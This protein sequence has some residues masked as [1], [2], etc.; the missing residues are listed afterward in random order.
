VGL[1]HYVSVANLG[2]Y[3]DK[4]GVRW[5]Y[6][7]RSTNVHNTYLLIHAE[8]GLLGLCGF[9][10]WLLSPILASLAA[11][12]RR[13]M[14]LRE[15]SAACGF[16]IAGT[17]LHSQYEWVTVTATPQYFIAL[18]A[19]VIAAVTSAS[20]RARRTRSAAHATKAGSGTMREPS[21]QPSTKTMGR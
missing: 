3:F 16:A 8:A 2:G 1:N 21:P 14:P 18:M 12:F 6:E 7:A 10:I 17:A 13:Q 20:A 19:G 15:V 5:G 9:L 4:A 11:L